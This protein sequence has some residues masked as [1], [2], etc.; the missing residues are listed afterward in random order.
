[1]RKSTRK[2]QKA[3]GRGVVGGG[4]GGGGPAKRKTGQADVDQLMQGIEEAVAS[5]GGATTRRIPDA[6]GPGGAL[7]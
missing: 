2:M 5:K 1:M 4:R 6:S 7:Q 3:K